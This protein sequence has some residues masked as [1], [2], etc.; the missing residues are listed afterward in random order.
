M[1]HHVLAIHAGPFRCRAILETETA[2][3]LVS[4][5]PH[6]DLHRENDSEKAGL[7][8]V[9]HETKGKLVLSRLDPN[10]EGT[11]QK[12]AV[13]LTTFLDEALPGAAIVSKGLTDLLLGKGSRLETVFLFRRRCDGGPRPSRAPPAPRV[14]PD[15]PPPSGAL[16]ALKATG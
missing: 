7:T 12:V 11:Q 3:D 15:T 8:V 10:R 1:V 2:L 5:V 6:I 9:P 16:P 4:K 13:D 14:A